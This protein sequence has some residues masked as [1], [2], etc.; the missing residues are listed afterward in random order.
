MKT[1]L[2]LKTN[3]TIKNFI[4]YNNKIYHFLN[5]PKMQAFIQL[6]SFMKMHWIVWIWC[7]KMS[8]CNLQLMIMQIT[9]RQIRDRNKSF[10]RCRWCSKRFKMSRIELRSHKKLIFLNNLMYTITKAVKGH[11]TTIIFRKKE[12]LL[13]KG[14][15]AKAPTLNWT[16][17]IIKNQIIKALT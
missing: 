17:I 11:R 4:L 3:L 12:I 5:R 6:N 14:I 7:L 15:L 16:N 8:L 1:F 13:L 10:Q 9:N 2:Y